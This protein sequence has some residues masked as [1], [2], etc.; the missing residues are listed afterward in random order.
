MPARRAG[1][2]GAAAATRAGCASARPRQFAVSIVAAP[3]ASLT[4]AHAGLREH[5]VHYS[6]SL[7][8]LAAMY[9]A[10]ELRNAANVFASPPP[11]DALER[12]GATFKDDIDAAV[13]R[14]TTTPG[15][16]PPA[17]QP[18]YRS[19]FATLPRLDGG[20]AFEFSAAFS[21]AMREMIVMSN[22]AAAASVIKGLGYSWINGVLSHAGLFAEATLNGIWL[23]GTFDSS[24]PY[25]RIPSVNDGMV[26]QATTCFEMANLLAN[27]FTGNA[28][29]IEAQPKMLQLLLDAQIEEASWI[30][31][32]KS[33]LPGLCFDVTHTK[34]GIGPL[35]TGA[36]VL[37]EASIL[38][39][40]ATGDL[41]IV[42]MQNCA[43]RD[44]QAMAFLVDRTIR[45]FLG[46]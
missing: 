34:I 46:I 19:V 32:R 7:L 21:T 15:F 13:P 22:N 31:F 5:E 4:F 12:L 8:K 28:V 6:A 14:I 20:V 24:I 1:A 23:A 44:Q 2:G 41:F 35:K 29:G 39:I 10:F 43:L 27:I 38:R 25:I 40:P 45:N 16:L 26:A 33:R 3:G 11:L 36:D 42:A 9:A 17:P 37:S 30:S 18:N